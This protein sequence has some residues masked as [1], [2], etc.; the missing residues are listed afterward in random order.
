MIFLEAQAYPALLKTVLR[1]EE[2]L[3][4][5]ELE[6]GWALQSPRL[7]LAI[8]TKAWLFR[9]RFRHFED[10]NEIKKAILKLAA[11]K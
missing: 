5:A 4:D 7:V 8:N 6:A 11:R 3:F 1:A 10:E 2:A 9:R